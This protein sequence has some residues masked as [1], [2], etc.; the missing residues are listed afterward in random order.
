MHS[1]IIFSPQF[2][3]KNNLIFLHHLRWIFAVSRSPQIANI[4]DIDC[5]PLGL[6]N[7]KLLVRRA[8][9]IQHVIYR[10]S[11]WYHQLGHESTNLH[12]FAHSSTEPR[13]SAP[14]W[15]SCPWWRMPI[16]YSTNSSV[17][18]SRLALSWPCVVA[19]H[20]LYLCGTTKFITSWSRESFLRRRFPN[21][22]NSRV[23]KVRSYSGKC[24]LHPITPLGIPILWVLQVFKLPFRDAELS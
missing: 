6:F 23:E 15:Q 12:S 19:W 2:A 21:A 22:P 5:H 7:N 4:Q 1:D 24:M 20:W 8:D 18:Q 3:T 13:Y 17:K 16:H 14:G 10:T 9:N 11:L